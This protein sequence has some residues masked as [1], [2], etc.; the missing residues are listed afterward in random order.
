MERL[1]AT[2]RVA[3]RLGTEYA[4]GDLG[5]ARLVDAHYLEPSIPATTPP[6]FLVDSGTV[7][8]VGELVS[9]TETPS[10]Y[11]VVGSGKTATDAIV[12]LLGNDVDADTIC[13]VRPRDPWMLNRAVVQPDPAV[14]IGMVADTLESAVGAASLDDLFL[15]LEAAGV[16]FRVDREVVPT[17]ART[18]TL[19]Q[20]ELD[21]LRSIEHVVRLGHVR[22][23]ER[24]SI[25]LDGGTSADSRR[26][27]R[28]AL[29]RERV[30]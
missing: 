23:V 17:M 28:R 15:R 19:A 5:S 10:Q 13:W 20:W 1:L 16:M 11:V 24:G 14:F 29:R 3:F 22:R 27:G 7:I 2:G 6:P 4:A 8:P 21:L 25:E 9:L 12:W 30:P 18:P 26:R